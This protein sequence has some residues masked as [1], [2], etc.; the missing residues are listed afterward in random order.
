VKKKQEKKGVDK[1]KAAG[2]DDYV[3]DPGADD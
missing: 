3:T 1:V 2:D